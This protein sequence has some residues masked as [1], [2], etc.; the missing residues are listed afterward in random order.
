M[1]TSFRAIGWLFGANMSDPFGCEG[2]IDLRKT[3]SIHNSEI[4]QFFATPE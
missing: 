1:V 3:L 2:D 4:N